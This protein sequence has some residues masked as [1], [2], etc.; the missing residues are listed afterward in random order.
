MI[1]GQTDLTKWCWWCGDPAEG[2][3]QIDSNHETSKGEFI[4]GHKLPACG[5]HLDHVDISKPLKK[6]KQTIDKKAEQTSMFD[7]PETER[8]PLGAIRND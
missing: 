4:E 1:E 6:P 5:Y 7:A 3:L 2:E 8:D